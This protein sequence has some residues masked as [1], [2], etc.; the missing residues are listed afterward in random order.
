MCADVTDVEPNTGTSG[1]AE[2]GRSGATGR[3]S[4]AGPLG[5]RRTVPTSIGDVTCYE[6]GAGPTLVFLHGLLVNAELWSATVPLL[7]D[8]HRCVTLELPLGAHP[9]PAPPD[10]D[11]TPGGIAAA[12]T[13][14]LRERAP[15]GSVLVGNDTGGVFAQLVATTSPELLLGLVLAS[16]DA[17]DNFLPWA[18]RHA[19][20]TARVRGGVW[21]MVQALRLRLVRDLPVACGWLVK[22]PV[23]ARLWQSFLGPARVDPEVRRDLGKFLRGV[24][25]GDTRRAA[26]ELRDFKQPTLLPWADTNRVFPVAH[27]HRLA[28]AMPNARVRPIPDS[29]ALVPLDQPEALAREIRAYV[30]KHVPPAF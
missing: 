19:Q 17:Y 7:A 11:L 13:E 15:E 26:R 1:T 29:Y 28:A 18:V 14:V 24:S 25:R 10:A 23:D 20:L 3:T 22:H 12:V 5:A 8:T 30:A 6:R 27:A 2:T 16:C 21:L 9:V 4:T